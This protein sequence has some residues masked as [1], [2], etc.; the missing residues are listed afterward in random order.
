MELRRPPVVTAKE[1]ERL[2]R[3]VSSLNCS[4]SEIGIQN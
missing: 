2:T 3:E 4:F 1:L